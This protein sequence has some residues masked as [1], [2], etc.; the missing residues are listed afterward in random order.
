MDKN[1]IREL[2]KGLSEEEYRELMEYIKSLT[3]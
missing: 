1:D 3:S 2:L